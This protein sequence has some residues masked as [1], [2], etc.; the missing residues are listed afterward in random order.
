MKAVPG[1]IWQSG[2][3]ERTY[4]PMYEN[5]VLS[6]AGTGGR[7]LSPRILPVIKEDCWPTL[8]THCLT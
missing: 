5:I 6:S 1:P 2:K 8:K 7:D 4:L 3:S